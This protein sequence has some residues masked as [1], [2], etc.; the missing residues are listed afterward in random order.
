MALGTHQW[1][2]KHLGGKPKVKLRPEDLIVPPM[3]SRSS[4]SNLGWSCKVGPAPTCKQTQRESMPPTFQRLSLIFCVEIK[5]PPN[6]F[7]LHAPQQELTSTQYK[8]S[9]IPHIEDMKNWSK[10]KTKHRAAHIVLENM[11]RQVE[12]P[13]R[14]RSVSPSPTLYLRGMKLWFE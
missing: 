10:S 9:S 11:E 13:E 8:R 7:K 2:P 3:G 4:H 6:L 1:T 12:S 5:Q 14:S